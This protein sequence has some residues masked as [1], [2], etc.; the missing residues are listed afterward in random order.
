MLDSL[1]LIHP[2][3]TMCDAFRTR[4]ADLPNVRVL[5]KCYEFEGP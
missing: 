3:E 5:Q 1:W 4:F 2:D